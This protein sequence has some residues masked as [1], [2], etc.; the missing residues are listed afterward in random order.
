MHTFV[1]VRSM[2][3]WAILQSLSV[4]LAEFVSGTSSV[5][6]S[7]LSRS[8]TRAWLP[9]W[10]VVYSSLL[11]PPR[12]I[13]C[14]CWLQGYP[15]E[16]IRVWPFE[17]RSNNTT[18]PGY[19]EKLDDSKITVTALLSNAC[20]SDDAHML[21]NWKHFGGKCFHEFHM[22]WSLSGKIFSVFVQRDV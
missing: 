9:W 14:I 17:K 3:L 6:K 10:Y 8:F 2:P 20:S 21:Y 12:V 11:R 13:R 1:R 4:A 7:R 18:R 22:L 15:S 19:L 5:W 16:C